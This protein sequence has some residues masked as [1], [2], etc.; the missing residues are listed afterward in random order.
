MKFLSSLIILI[1]LTAQAQT[2]VQDHGILEWEPTLPVAAHKLLDVLQMKAFAEF[3]TE[4]N[5]TACGGELIAPA[6]TDYYTFYSE[7]NALIHKIKLQ[8]TVTGSFNYCE[9]ETISVCTIP[10]V[11]KSEK[12]FSMSDWDCTIVGFKE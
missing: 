6:L 8:V 9:K 2:S 12:Q 4:G 3:Y 7:D 1:G 11:M 10:L 5:G